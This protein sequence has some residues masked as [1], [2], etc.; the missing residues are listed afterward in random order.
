MTTT[1][2]T[3]ITATTSRAE[4]GQHEQVPGLQLH[5]TGPGAWR[6]VHTGSGL[7][8]PMVGWPTDDLPR[9]AAE[10]A[11]AILVHT[12]TQTGIDWTRT[13]G[14]LRADLDRV[15]PVIRD[16]AVIARACT[17]NGHQR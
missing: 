1:I 16:A 9:Y 4:S 12:G 15:G 2:A 10:I 7:H 17:P 11:L 6:I 13:A 8:L 14:Q 3:A 5:Q